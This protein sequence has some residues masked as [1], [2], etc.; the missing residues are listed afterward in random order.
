MSFYCCRRSFTASKAGGS[1]QV[2]V[3][4]HPRRVGVGWVGLLHLKGDTGCVLSK[5]A[6][7]ALYSHCSFTS[8]H[9]DRPTVPSP[10]RSDIF[11]CPRG[12][13]RSVWGCIFCPSPHSSAG[14]IAWAGASAM[15]AAPSSLLTQQHPWRR[16]SVITMLTLPRT[17]RVCT[18]VS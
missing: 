11:P 12:R 17:F 4:D 16:G 13:M 8:K 10:W 2:K 7:D 1:A 18:N 3:F 14:L 6:C 5:K 9:C 15:P